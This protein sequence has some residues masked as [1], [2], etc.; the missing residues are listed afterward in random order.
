MFRTLTYIILLCSLLCVSC[1]EE[2]SF[3]SNHFTPKIVLNS[4]FTNDSIWVISLAHTTSIFDKNSD[5]NFIT[6]AIIGITNVKGEQVCELYHEGKGIYKSFKCVCANDELY[7][8]NVFSKKYGSV[9][10]HSKVPNKTN[11]NNLQITVSKEY[12]NASEVEFKI[13]DNS[14]DRNYYIWSIVDVDTLK[15]QVTSNVNSKLDFKLWISEIREQ[16]GKVTSGKLSNTGATTDLDLE[17]NSS[18]A[19]LITNKNL[20]REDGTSV[21][22]EK[23][24]VPM[25]KLMTVSP[26]LYNYYKSMEAYLK[27]NNTASSVAEPQK[28]FSNVEGGLGIFA[29]YSIQYYTIPEPK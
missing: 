4:I 22:Y 21:P 8:I 15:N 11:I 28:L 25:L 26:E 18:T 14:P 13:E 6:D 1:E 24:V 17:S 19:K 7:N 27:Y 2:I 9:Y 16:F 3:E 10:A 20:K 23:N 5:Q 12:T 29:G